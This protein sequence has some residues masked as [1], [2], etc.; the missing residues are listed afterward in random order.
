M[1]LLQVKGIT[2]LMRLTPSILTSKVTRPLARD[3][4]TT[5]ARNRLKAKFM[6]MLTDRNMFTRR[7]QKSKSLPRMTTVLTNTTDNKNEVRKRHLITV[8]HNRCV[9]KTVCHWRSSRRRF[10]GP[11]I[12]GN[13]VVR[14]DSYTFGGPHTSR[15]NF[16]S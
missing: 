12:T 7:P 8:R 6:C 2:H 11:W 10:I 14:G 1:R 9:A 5:K 13:T 4:V 3:T 16:R 15:T